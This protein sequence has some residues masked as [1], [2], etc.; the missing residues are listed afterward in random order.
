MRRRRLAREAGATLRLATPIIV[1]QLAQVSLG[2]VD[3]V[4]VGRLGPEALAAVA[5]GAAPF[6]A[7][8][9]V[10]L[11]VC[12]ATEPLVS[13]AFGAGDEARVARSVHSG[14]WAA[15]LLSLPA[16]LLMRGA[17]ALL[18]WPPLGQP[19]ETAHAAHAYLDALTWGIPGFLVF[20]A[21]R[22][23][24]EGVS[25]PLA[26]TVIALASVGVNVVANLALIFGA[27]GAPALGVV[28]AGYASAIAST[29]SA[30]ALAAFVVLHP[31]LRRARPLRIGRPHGPTLREIAHVGLPLGGTLFV[32][33]GFFGA[34]ALMMGRLGATSL[35]AHQIAIQCASVTFMTALGTALAGAVRVGQ[36]AGRG[37]GPG[38]RRAGFVAIGLALAFMTLSAAAFRTL[39]DRI[40]ALY[41]DPADPANAAV[42]LLATRLLAIA[43]VF[44]LFDGL[45]VSSAGALRGLKDTRAAF[46]VV[47]VAY[48]GIGLGTGLTFAFGLGG[49]APGLWWGLVVGLLAAG[50]GLFGR[51]VNRTR[52]PRLAAALAD[53]RGK[54]ADDARIGY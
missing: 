14:L 41:L 1:S 12:L 15:L 17:G 25:R 27:W 18:A 39:P 10:F 44:Q 52:G 43:G 20:G 11:G 30:L 6:F 35:A 54:S 23:Y 3:T 4:M 8:A 53:A 13:Q 38:V 34:T 32:E 28:G 51:F 9:L 2:F 50:I 46:V 37:D 40:I 7:L 47:L 45:Q 48:W 36:A 16:M 33:A 19:P 21:L 29:F 5:L 49:G 26:V 22:S 42:V 31:V 24:C